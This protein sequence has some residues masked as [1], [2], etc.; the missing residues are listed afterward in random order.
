MFGTAARH[1]FRRSACGNV[2]QNVCVRYSGQDLNVFLSLADERVATVVSRVLIILN[3]CAWRKKLYIN[4][5]EAFCNLWIN[6]VAII[7]QIVWI[8]RRPVY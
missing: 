8:L 6:C 5:R 3:I 2:K 1:Y 4:L 7:I